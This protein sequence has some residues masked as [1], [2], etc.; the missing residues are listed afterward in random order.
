MVFLIFVIASNP[1]NNPPLDPQPKDGS[2]EA[3]T[4]AMIE[5]NKKKKAMQNSGT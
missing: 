2:S 5:S 3:I 4:K 1:W